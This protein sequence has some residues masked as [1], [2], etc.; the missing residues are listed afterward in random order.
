[1]RDFLQHGRDDIARDHH[2]AAAHAGDLQ[3]AVLHVIDRMRFGGSDNLGI[4]LPLGVKAARHR[5]VELDHVADQVGLA[6]IGLAGKPHVG[7]DK[8]QMREFRILVVPARHGQI[9]HILD[10]GCRRT[11]Q[12]SWNAD[13]SKVGRQ[14]EQRLRGDCVHLLIGRGDVD[15]NAARPGHA[16]SAL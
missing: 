3:E 1:V 4:G 13:R 7:I 2:H 16:A 12:S 8:Q 5:L 6:V 10:V 15:E 11:L 14:I 9:A